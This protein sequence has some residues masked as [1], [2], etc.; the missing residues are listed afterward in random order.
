ML[1]ECFLM[2]LNSFKVICSCRSVVGRSSVVGRRSVVSRSSIGRRSLISWLSVGCRL[3]VGRSLIGRWSV[4]GRLLVGRWSSC[5]TSLPGGD[6]VDGLP[7]AA[8]TKYSCLETL[9]RSKLFVN[10]MMFFEKSWIFYALTYIFGILRFS[11]MLM[12]KRM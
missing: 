8:S 12:L 3:I 1:L 5:S 9:D 11:N 10:L 7:S 2:I 4:I 6:Q